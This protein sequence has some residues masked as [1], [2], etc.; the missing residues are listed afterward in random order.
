M[1]K[2]QNFF[3]VSYL[4]IGNQ[5]PGQSNFIFHR[6]NMQRVNMRKTTMIF[7]INLS[8]NDYHK[9]IGY[10]SIGVENI[11]HSYR[12]DLSGT[13]CKVNNTCMASD[14]YLIWFDE[15]PLQV[16]KINSPNNC[17]TSS[18]SK[19]FL[20]TPSGTISGSTQAKSKANF[21]LNR[22]DITL[23]YLQM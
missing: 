20:W 23:T 12:I 7:D 17:S 9:K 4:K 5:P 8:R 21:E 14:H 13:P 19:E 1:N 18:R 15:K 11:G 6:C 3:Y 22:L 2:L 16:Y 10:T